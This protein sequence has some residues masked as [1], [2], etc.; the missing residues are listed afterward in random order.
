MISETVES[1]SKSLKSPDERRE[2]KAHGHM[3][4][5]NLPENISIGRAEFEPGWKWSQDIKPMAKTESCQASHTGYCLKGT[6]VI[7]MDNGTEFTIHEGDAFHIPPG[8]D[9]WVE[10]NETCVLVDVG[11]YK[12]Y[13]K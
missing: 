5:V 10:G 13:A 6:M 1:Y 8:H 11:G 9:G 2:F 7:H 12:T 4:L 3:D